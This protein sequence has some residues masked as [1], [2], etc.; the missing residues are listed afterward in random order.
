[1]DLG[2]CRIETSLD[3]CK[4]AEQIVVNSGH[5]QGV[6]VWKVFRLLG[7]H[8]C[9]VLVGDYLLEHHGCLFKLALKQAK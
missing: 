4:F 5:Q 7:R 8:A 2:S 9:L 6:V 3:L 1:M